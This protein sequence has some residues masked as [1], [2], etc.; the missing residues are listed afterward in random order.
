MAD[1]ASLS[2]A[3]RSSGGDDIARLAVEAHVDR[4]RMHHTSARGDSIV[5]GLSK[6][7]CVVSITFR[8][9]SALVES[10]ER[11]SAGGVVSRTGGGGEGILIADEV[12]SISSRQLCAST[13]LRSLNDHSSLVTF[14]FLR[15]LVIL[16]DFMC[17]MLGRSWRST[18]LP[19][20]SP[21]KLTARGR[22]VGGHLFKG[23]CSM[24]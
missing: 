9:M 24:E 4:K 12:S 15:P 19:L 2:T 11:Y 23:W 17:G 22:W 6:K 20:S 13:L 16:F 8:W 10:L 1:S 18:V 21:R 3:P 5:S 14:S 7:G